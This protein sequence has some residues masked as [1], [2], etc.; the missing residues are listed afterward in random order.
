MVRITEMSLIWLILKPLKSIRRLPRSTPVTRSS[1]ESQGLKLNERQEVLN[2]LAS[3]DDM[4]SASI[5]A[6]IWSGAAM[7]FATI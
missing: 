1:D 6:G 7:D 2:G 4:P 5:V 3:P